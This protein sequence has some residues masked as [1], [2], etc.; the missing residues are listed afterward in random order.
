MNQ[1][2]QRKMQSPTSLPRPANK[3]S[4]KR[5]TDRE[6]LEQLADF[7]NKR[8]YIQG[9]E[10]SIRDMVTRY[11]NPPLSR[12]NRVAMRMTVSEYN[13]LT[14]LMQKV[15]RHLQSTSHKELETADDR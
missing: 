12:L 11:A 13:Q 4:N 3:R 14:S 1:R 15:N 10:D 8:A 6:L 7:L 9:D 5:L 2:L